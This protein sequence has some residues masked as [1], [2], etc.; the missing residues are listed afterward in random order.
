MSSVGIFRQEATADVEEFQIMRI[1]KA[2]FLELL[3]WKIWSRL[4]RYVQQ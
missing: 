4:L 1:I 2:R 3:S